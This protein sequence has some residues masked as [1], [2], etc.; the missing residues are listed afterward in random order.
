MPQAQLPHQTP[1]LQQNN[2][3]LIRNV[4]L[5]YHH[6][7]KITIQILADPTQ[8]VRQIWRKIRGTLDMKRTGDEEVGRLDI[9]WDNYNCLDQLA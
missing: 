2:T 4:P 3:P 6:F 8:P 1:Q 7:L 5:P 9:N